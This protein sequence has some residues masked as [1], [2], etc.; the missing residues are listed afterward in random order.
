MTTLLAVAH[1]GVVHMAADSL[2]NVYERPVVGVRKI[3]RIPVADQTHTNGE[4]LIGVSGDGALAALLRFHLK[5]DSAPAGTALADLDG[6]DGPDAWAATV[7]QAITVIAQEH[8]V[9]ED[10][11]LDGHLVLGYAGRVWTVVHCQAIPHGDGVA[12]IGS[13]E[14][15]AIGAVDALLSTGMDPARAVP[16]AVRIGI[17]R[18]KHSAGPVDYQRLDPPTTPLPTTLPEDAQPEDGKGGQP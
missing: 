17:E 16:M 14:G 10:G 3:L 5:L 6:P 9:L 2:T 11:R 8:G 1:A 7:A 12:A 18:D 15:P 4:V 13:G